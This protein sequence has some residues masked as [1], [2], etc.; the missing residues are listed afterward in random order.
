VQT[1]LLAGPWHRGAVLR[2]GASAHLLP[3]HFGQA[4]A[5][6]VEDATLLGRLL[7]SASDRPQLLA[8]FN[9]RRAPRAARVHAITTQAAHWDLHP[10]PATDFPALARQLVPI[11]EHAA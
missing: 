3:P 9:A 1:G 6:S 10:E 5:Q 8:Q 11:V 2:I 7:A 4:A